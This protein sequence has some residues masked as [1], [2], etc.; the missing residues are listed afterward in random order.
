MIG[1][2]EGTIRLKKKDAIVVLAQGVGYIIFVS[3]KLL[4]QVTLQQSVTLYIH[5]HVKEDELSLYGFSTEE[6]LTLFELLISISGIGPKTA[7]IVVGNGVQLVRQAVVKADV[8]FFKTIPRLGTKNAQ[9]IIIELKNK[10]ED[11]ATLDMSAVGGETQ[12]V[13]EALIATGFSRQEAL[14]AVRQLPPKVQKIEE[15]IR[16]ALKYLGEKR[17]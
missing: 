16:L 12:D 14:A 17:S 5:T 2:I 4:A 1:L 9:K 10:F 11:G 8:S 6:E 7:L 15:K 3:Q 13:L